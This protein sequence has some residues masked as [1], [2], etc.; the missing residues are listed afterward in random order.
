MAW[1]RLPI[2]A[3]ALLV[4]ASC[5]DEGDAEPGTNVAE[6]SGWWLLDADGFILLAGGLTSDDVADSTGHLWTLEYSDGPSTLQLSAW[7]SG[8]R[9][10]DLI[11]EYPTVGSTEVAGYDVTLR[12]Y[13]GEP[14]DDI[15]ASLVAVWRDGDRVIGLGGGGLSEEQARSYLDDLQ[16]VTRSEWGAAVDA[17]PEPPPPPTP[18]SLGD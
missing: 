13:P 4:L 8:S 16:R 3:V 17:L 6:P 14:S 15:R 18:T 5:G 12:R 9:F 11:E 7:A 10:L 2:I 1:L